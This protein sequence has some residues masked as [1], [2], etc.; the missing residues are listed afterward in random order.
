MCA[1]S[2]CAVVLLR[3]VFPLNL[4]LSSTPILDLWSATLSLA[5]TWFTLP[6]RNTHLKTFSILTT[7][8]S[9]CKKINSTCQSFTNFLIYSFL[10]IVQV[11]FKLRVQVLSM[12]LIQYSSKEQIH[13][14]NYYK[15]NGNLLHAKKTFRSELLVWKHLTSMG[16]NSQDQMLCLE[17]IEDFSETIK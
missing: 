7:I 2:P 9:G 1:I 12:L 5:Y 8:W 6:G 14:Q 15:A 10:C 17:F 16:M 3:A 13:L 11:I 4:L